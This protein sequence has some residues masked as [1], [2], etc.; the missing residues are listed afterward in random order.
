MLFD[1]FTSNLAPWYDNFEARNLR[2]SGQSTFAYGVRTEPTF[3]DIVG[4]ALWASG[5]LGSMVIWWQ[6]K[7]KD[8]DQ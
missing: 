5:A 3:A 4:Y 7:P 6:R 8:E 1:Y 2:W